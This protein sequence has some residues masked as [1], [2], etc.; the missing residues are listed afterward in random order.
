MT[1]VL[2]PKLFNWKIRAMYSPV[3]LEQRSHGVDR[4]QYSVPG[5]G[6]DPKAALCGGG[7]GGES[8]ENAQIVA[9]EDGGG[10]GSLDGIE[11]SVP[12]D[13]VYGSANG[14]VCPE[15]VVMPPHGGDVSNQLTL[16]FRGQVYVFDAVTAE[17]VRTLFVLC[18]GKLVLFLLA[19]LESNS[20]FVKNQSFI[21]FTSISAFFDREFF[22]FASVIVN[23]CSRTFYM[24][25]LTK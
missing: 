6:D 10:I 15:G 19:L 23:D 4:D 20:C 24:L 12:H 22:L 8:I 11:V 14:G 9:F 13:S 17:K 5:D 25:S 2:V 16:S 7:G 1:T 3:Q 18:C 21:S